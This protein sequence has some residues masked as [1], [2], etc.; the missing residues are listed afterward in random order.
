QL[1]QKRHY[2]RRA[3]ANLFSDH[4]LFARGR[5]R[6]S[7]HYPTFAGCPGKTPEFADVRVGCGFGGLLIA[8]APL[9]PDTRCSVS[10]RRPLKCVDDLWHPVPGHFLRVAASQAIDSS[11]AWRSAFK[12]REL[13]R[14]KLFEFP[15][16]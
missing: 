13:E 4:A 15:D 11:K 9:F 12:L 2:R 14:A 3:H 6:L 8:L 1:H 7:V 10:V 5:S 16:S